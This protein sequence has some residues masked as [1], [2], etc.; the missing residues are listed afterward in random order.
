MLTDSEKEKIAAEE[1]YRAQIRASQPPMQTESYTD[2]INRRERSVR[3]VLAVVVLLFML[4]ATLFF[5]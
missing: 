3:V 1:L 2:R 5:R 4:W